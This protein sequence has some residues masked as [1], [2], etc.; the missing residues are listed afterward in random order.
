MNIQE[1]FI[2]YKTNLE[3]KNKLSKLQLSKSKEEKFS[4]TKTY[5]PALLEK[6]RLGN[7]YTPIIEAIFN[8]L[9]AIKE[10]KKDDGEIIID[11]LREGTESTDELV[12]NQIIGFEI[13][14]NGIGITNENRDAFDTIFTNKN[15][16]D[17][18]KGFGRLMYLK[19]FDTVRIESVYRENDKFRYRNFNVGRYYDLIEA[20]EE[21]D[22]DK[23]TTY[24]KVF[25]KSCKREYEKNLEVIARKILEQ[26][27]TIFITNKE[28]VPKII[29]KDAHY[30]KNILLNDYYDNNDEI[31]KIESTPVIIPTD[32]SN[33]EQMKRFQIHIFKN[34][35]SQDLNKL[36]LVADDRTVTENSLKE[37][38]PEFDDKF[39]DV[40]DD[41]SK[42]FVLKAYLTGEY[43]DKNVTH[44]RDKFNFDKTESSEFYPYSKFELE[45]YIS[46][47]LRNIYSEEI[48]NRS[49]KKRERINEYISNEAPWYKKYSSDLNLDKLG[50]MPSNEEIEQQ[51]HQLAYQ[52]EVRAKQSAKEILESDNIGFNE[53]VEQIVSSLTDLNK[54]ELAKYVVVRKQILKL[55]EDAVRRNRDG[56]VEDEKVFHNI[57]FPMNNDITQVKYNDHNLWLLD[58][59][60]VFSEFVASD[61]KI[62][63]SKEGK[64]PD[65]IIFNKR[66]TF[67]VGSNQASNPLTIFEFKKPKRTGYSEKENPIDQIYKYAE[68]IR[69]GK[70]E[71]PDGLEELKVEDNTPIYGII[72]CDIVDKI[73]GFAKGASLTIS[74]DKEGFYGFHPGYGIYYEIISYSKL[75]KDATQRNKIFFKKLGIDI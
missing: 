29:L 70:Y 64:E 25:L 31:I 6:T 24:T 38:I 42:S 13:F 47:Y 54:N 12:L 2:Q 16:A 23:Q 26:L 27:L 8:S 57:V 53:R 37:Y 4:M 30:N 40:K 67:R 15:I 36:F 55:F 49:S 22:I 33:N 14:D 18:G 10:A 43:L 41:T 71:T 60:L 3:M 20:I 11:V 59:R 69:K 46:E 9:R 65:L 52:D 50:L 74:P 28:S 51:L 39:I 5:I 21:G 34:Y 72:I 56:S 48:Y 1:N 32:L 68:L 63:K 19:F 62:N 75:L 61:R 44:D 66:N 7:R 58:E 35:F 73:K 45:K 17:G